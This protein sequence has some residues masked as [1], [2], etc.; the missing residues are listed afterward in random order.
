MNQA[1]EKNQLRTGEYNAHDKAFKLEMDAL[2]KQT[3]KHYVA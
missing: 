2:V 3:K 1:R